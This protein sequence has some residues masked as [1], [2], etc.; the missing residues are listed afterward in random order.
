[1]KFPAWYIADM[2]GTNAIRGYRRQQC[3]KGNGY[4]LQQYHNLS[5]PL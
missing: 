3:Q 4:L 2:L 5:E 1:M